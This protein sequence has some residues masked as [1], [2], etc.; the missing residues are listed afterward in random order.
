MK[1]IFVLLLFFIFKSSI[2]QTGGISGKLIADDLEGFSVKVFI[3][4]LDKYTVTKDK[5]FE[6]KAIPAGEYTLKMS[7]LG[8]ESVSKNVRVRPDSITKVNIQLT[9]RKNTLDEVVIIDRQTGLNAK[10]PYNFVP[11]SLDRIV[12]KSDPSG[13]MGVLRE[14]PGVYGAEFGQ[15]IVK[16]FIRG[17]GFSRVVTIYQGNK[18]ENQQWGADHG[19]GVNDLGVK[20]VDIIKG[21]ASVL[22]GS[23]AL[24]GVILIKDDEFYKDADKLSGNLGTSFNSVSNG[25]RGFASLGKRF[26][27]DLYF[28]TD[29]AYED[30]AD[31]RAGNGDLI[32]NSRYDVATA[33]FHIGM[34]KED[35]ENKLSLSFNSQN[36]GIIED[37]ELE[38]PSTTTRNDREE[39]LPYQEVTDVLVAYNQRIDHDSFESVFH[40][41]HHYNDRKEIE[42]A[43]DLIDLGFKQ[44]NTFYN[45]RVNFDTGD[46]THNIGLQG[47]YLDNENQEDVLDILIPDAYYTENGAYYR[48]NYEWGSYF[49]QGALRYD[50]RYVKADASDDQ[51][52][53]AGFVLPGE[54][55]SRTLTSTFSGLTG[56]IGVTREMGKG[57]KMK[58]NLSSGFRSPDLAELYSFGQHPGTNRFEIGNADFDREQSFQLDLNYALNRD[59]FRLDWS[60]FGSRI[61]NY[62]FFSDTGNVQEES[63]LQIWQYQQVQ[64]Q[65]Y[66]SEFALQYVALANRQLKLNLGAALVRGVN[67]DIDEPLTFIPP[68]NINFR[69]E[70]GFGEL[71]KTSLFL[72][73]RSVA[74]QDRP[75]PN[76]EETPG[77]TLLDVGLKRQFK[78][79]EAHELE[80]SLSFKNVLDENYVD[81]LSI[82]RAFNIPSPGRNITLNLRF[83]F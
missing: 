34:D 4:E 58:M 9:A 31:Y 46:F 64:A 20:E 29:L 63:G 53:D 6:F 74:R 52:V 66:G 61:D 21:P 38:D 50:H 54:P 15:G 79:W 35:F 75:G 17:L 37:D 28:G 14:V 25:L 13:V 73:S 11:V 30:H 47:N 7:A 36:L 56:S 59:R 62:I 18:L 12:G 68:D 44:H 82:L 65:L 22:Y 23:G 51:F 10:T 72:S 49:F 45:A 39:Q 33:R 67:K 69:A 40:L 81:H 77:Y 83:Y 80:A 5:T 19:L 57:Q 24:G 43:E 41:S 2:G 71:Q 55:E 42:T 26:E 27:N 1:Y 76:E 60:V 48:I 3:E 16:P 70:Y 32:G 78:L 8:Y